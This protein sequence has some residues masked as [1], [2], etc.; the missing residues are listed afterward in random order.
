MRYRHEDAISR[1]SRVRAKA[2]SVAGRQADASIESNV[3]CLGVEVDDGQCQRDL[4]KSEL[5]P[6]RYLT[7]LHQSGLSQPNCSTDEALDE[8]V[9]KRRRGFSGCV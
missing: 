2:Q 4:T 3:R 1:T 9:T 5:R 6:V 8:V 7:S